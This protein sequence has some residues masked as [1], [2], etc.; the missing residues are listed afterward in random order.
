[1]AGRI[2]ASILAYP[3]LKSLVQNRGN[4]FM[5]KIQVKMISDVVCPWCWVGKRNLEKAIDMG[6]DKYEV[7]V[8]W[9]PFLLRPDAPKEGVAK[10]PNT[11]TNP[12]VGHS[13]RQSGLN[14]GIDFTGKCDRTPNSVKSHNLLRFAEKHAGAETQNK[15]QEALFSAYFTDGEDLNN[16]FLT[17]VAI[18]A[19]LE[20]DMVRTYIESK[21]ADEITYKEAADHRLNGVQSIP[22]CI[23][24]GQEM[25]AGAQPVEQFLR[26]FEIAPEITQ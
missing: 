1:M 26:A 19:G 4:K 10:A 15:I 5:K 6:R 21:E 22:F 2:S 20:P 9:L 11:P 25:F 14:A 3:H 23:V 18:E 8:K 17:K 12:R 24:N 13:L 16:E 7:T